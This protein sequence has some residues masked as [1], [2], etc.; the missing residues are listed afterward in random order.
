MRRVIRMQDAG[1][2]RPGDADERLS[3]QAQSSVSALS[4]EQGQRARWALC[5]YDARASSEELQ[6]VHPRR[7]DF[8]VTRRQQAV[9]SELELTGIAGTPVQK[10]S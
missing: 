2:A 10:R 4:D 3:R 7:G 9:A 1:D 6:S 5:R 8:V